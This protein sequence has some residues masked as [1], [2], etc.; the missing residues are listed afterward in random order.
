MREGECPIGAAISDIKDS[1]LLRLIEHEDTV[2]QTLHS[3]VP[4]SETLSDVR[5]RNSIGL[6]ALVP[7]RCKPRFG[8]GIPP[9]GPVDMF[10]ADEISRFLS[11]RDSV[12]GNL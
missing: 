12:H 3:I 11:A 6:L 4:I 5:N 2:H 1:R 9:M 7:I 8:Q 10:E